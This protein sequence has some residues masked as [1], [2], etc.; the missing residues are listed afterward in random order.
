MQGVGNSTGG[1]WNRNSQSSREKK[2]RNKQ[3]DQRTNEHSFCSGAGF[4]KL[5]IYK[6]LKCPSTSITAT[7][8]LKF[9]L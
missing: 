5:A 7:I 9:K 1:N 4:V 8:A 6:L 3:I 2:Q